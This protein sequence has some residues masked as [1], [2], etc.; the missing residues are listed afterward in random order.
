L[1][2]RP[3]FAL[4]RA[5][6]IRKRADFLRIQDGTA[7]VTTRHLLVLLGERPDGASRLGI[8]ASRKVGGAVERNRAKR[9]VRE[10]FRL[11]P[12]AIPSGV[13]LVVIVRPGTHLLSA[14]AVAAELVGAAPALARRA[15]E[16][17]ARRKSHA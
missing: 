17:R 11:H 10:A 14:D 16:V 6:R 4:P 7:R 1:G 13:D 5:R 2:D 3:R 9:L 12:E 15:S 8:V